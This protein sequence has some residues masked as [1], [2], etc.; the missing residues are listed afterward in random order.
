MT[1][2]ATR[3]TVNVLLIGSTPVCGGCGFVMRNQGQ[4]DLKTGAL[5]VRCTNFDC[6]NYFKLLEVSF[7]VVQCKVVQPRTWPAD[8]P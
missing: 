1:G 3:A 7:P 5:A 4:V 6:D 8:A 2:Y